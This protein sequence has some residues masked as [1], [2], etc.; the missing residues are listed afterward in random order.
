MKTEN[1]KKI[2][3]RNIDGDFVELKIGDKIKDAGR[4]LTVDRISEEYGRTTICTFDDNNNLVLCF[5]DN[6]FETV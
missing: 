5:A 1:L 4:I 6:N 2:I 3:V